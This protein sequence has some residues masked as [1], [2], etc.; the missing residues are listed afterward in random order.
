MNQVWDYTYSAEYGTVTVH[1]HRLRAKI[2]ADPLKPSYIKTLW[3]IGY[4]FEGGINETG[5]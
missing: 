3:G 4:K 5:S 1:I 2:E